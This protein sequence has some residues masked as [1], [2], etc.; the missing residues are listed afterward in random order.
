MINKRIARFAG[1][2]A[3]IHILKYTPFSVH[4]KTFR[5]S[6]AFCRIRRDKD[7]AAH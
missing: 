6:T 4:A 5:G 1:S 2:S 7:S 3:L